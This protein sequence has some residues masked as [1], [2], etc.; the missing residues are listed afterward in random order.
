MGTRRGARRPAD[1]HQTPRR[2]RLAWTCFPPL[3]PRFGGRGAGGEGGWACRIENKPPRAARANPPHPQPLSPRSGGRG[4]NE[5]AQHFVSGFAASVA[6]LVGPRTLTPLV[7]CAEHLST[8]G[9]FQ[10]LG[11]RLPIEP[12]LA[13]RAI[14]IAKAAV[15]CVSGLAGY[16]GVDVVLGDDGRDWAIEINPRLDDELRRPASAGE[17][18]HRRRHARG[19]KWYDSA[20][21][22]MA[23]RGD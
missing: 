21:D 22:G 16:V 8:D 3:S 11:G 18:Q 15:T 10:Y 19:R 4:E 5:I 23:R 2:R 6:F 9:R 1:G 20:A 14:R 12:P 7:P 13:E 17:V